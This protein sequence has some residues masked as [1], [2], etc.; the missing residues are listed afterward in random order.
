VTR[1]LADKGQS[2]QVSHQPGHAGLGF[3]LMPTRDIELLIEKTR[4][5]HLW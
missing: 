4:N 1:D 2:G 5:S 3:S